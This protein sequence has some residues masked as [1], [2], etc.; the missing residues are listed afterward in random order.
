MNLDKLLRDVSVVVA[1]NA[2]ASFSN[3]AT[4]G[5]ALTEVA[6]ILH[7]QAG[8]VLN[9]VEAGYPLA[10]GGVGVA[11]ALNLAKDINFGHLPKHRGR[12]L[13]ARCV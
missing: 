5:V 6:L 13:S 3:G 11:G 8:A 4:F 2:F 1:N 12:H 7:E 9:E 10:S